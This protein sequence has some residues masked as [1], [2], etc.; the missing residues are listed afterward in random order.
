MENENELIYQLA[1]LW[2]KGVGVL[3]YWDDARDEYMMEWGVLVAM[4]NAVGISNA[5]TKNELALETQRIV[6]MRFD[7]LDQRLVTP[8]ERTIRIAIRNLRRAGALIVSSSAGAGYWRAE[9]MDE[10]REFTKN[11]FRD[12]AL[13]MMVTARNMRRSAFAVF[14][15]QI[16]LF[17]G[18]E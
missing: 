17:A 2:N 6:N 1:D 11:E 18:G 12:R 15:R 13:D 5:I 3:P 4:R 9:S 16:G 8:T 14:G 10:I 7:R